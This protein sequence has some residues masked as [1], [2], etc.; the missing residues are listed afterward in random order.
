M[1]WFNFKVWYYEGHDIEVIRRTFAVFQLHTIL[2]A[3]G[4][5][6]EVVGGNRCGSVVV[7]EPSVPASK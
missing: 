4:G 2:L 1:T 6:E 3:F 5:D 7:Q